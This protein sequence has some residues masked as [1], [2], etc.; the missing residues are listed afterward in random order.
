MKR[1]FLSIGG[2]AAVVSLAI[3]LNSAVAHLVAAVATG[4]LG[5]AVPFLAFNRAIRDLTVAHA[6]LI[7]NRIP[8]LAAGGAVAA[9]GERLRWPEIVGGL[10]VVAAATAAATLDERSVVGHRRRRLSRC[11]SVVG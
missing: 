11:A 10:L 4:L 8:V 2:L 9:L 7:L 3:G 1:L 5:G 6:G